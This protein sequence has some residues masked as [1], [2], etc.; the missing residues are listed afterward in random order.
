MSLRSSH[1]LS[2]HSASLTLTGFLQVDAAHLH[3]YISVYLDTLILR[4]LPSLLSPAQVQILQSGKQILSFKLGNY[5]MFEAKSEHTFQQGRSWWNLCHQ[6]MQGYHALPL[7]LFCFAF[8][9]TQKNLFVWV[10]IHVTHMWMSD[11]FGIIASPPTTQVPRIELE[12]ISLG[13]KVCL[14]TEPFSWPLFF[15]GELGQ[16]LNSLACP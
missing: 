8:K 1:L 7:F 9:E 2:V 11:K 6:A 12:V 10:G 5:L 3:C 15:G 14:P 4:Y 13:S 16:T